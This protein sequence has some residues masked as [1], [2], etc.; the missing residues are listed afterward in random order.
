MLGGRDVAE[1]AEEAAVVET[2]DP[3]QRGE[4]KAAEPAGATCVVA[5]T[6]S[7]AGAQGARCSGHGAVPFGKVVHVFDV[8]RLEAA[9]AQLL[10]CPAI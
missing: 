5:F 4:F 2:V 3:F 1:R 10:S 9:S 6:K 8:D 7:G